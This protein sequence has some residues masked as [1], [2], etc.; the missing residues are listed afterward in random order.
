MSSSDRL[1]IV[2]LANSR[3]PPGRCVAGIVI[4]NDGSFGDWVRPI[5]LSNKNA[6][7]VSNTK[8]QNEVEIKVLDIVS[9][10]HNGLAHNIDFQKENLVVK[11]Q[12][13]FE[14]IF[15][16]SGKM[17]QGS[18]N[19]VI[20]DKVPWP[21]S[22][23]EDSSYGMRNNRISEQHLGSVSNSLCL[24]KKELKIYSVS[25][26]QGKKRLVGAFSDGYDKYVLPITCPIMENQ[27]KLEV[28][29]P[30]VVFPKAIMCL[31]LG[32]IFQGFSYKLIASVI[33][34]H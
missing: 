4:K 22:P 15:F 13:R 16:H 10:S 5:I 19:S 30:P 6:L 17:Q 7:S 33:I 18:L 29:D 1:K 26:Y 8:N 31:S 34:S 3:K 32:E 14:G 9:F 25:G 24:I 12:S 23:T 27:L 2:V 11:P 21:V 28:K 20:L